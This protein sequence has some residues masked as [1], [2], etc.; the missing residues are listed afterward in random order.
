[1]PTS[2]SEHP[3]YRVWISLS[4]IAVFDASYAT[5]DEPD[6]PEEEYQIANE[7][8]RQDPADQE[9]DEPDPESAYLKLVVTLKP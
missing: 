7:N 8:G 4:L 1:L 9:V 3:A 6:Q 2:D 5:Y